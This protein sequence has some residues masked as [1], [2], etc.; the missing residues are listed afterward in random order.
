MIYIYTVCSHDSE[1]LFVSPEEERERKEL[2]VS[3]EC[4]DGGVES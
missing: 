1:R 2:S 4:G 3:V